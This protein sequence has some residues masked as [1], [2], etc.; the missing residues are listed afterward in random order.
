VPLLHLPANMS[1]S[2]ESSPQ[3]LCKGPCGR[4]HD[5]ADFYLRGT[6]RRGKLYRM[7]VCRTCH[8][9][10]QRNRK[11]RRKAHGPPPQ[12]CMNCGNAAPLAC[13]HDHQTGEFRGWLC[14]NCN[15]GLGLL[16]DDAAGLRRMLAYLTR[17][18][19]S[20]SGLDSEERARSRSPSRHGDF[21]GAAAS[22]TS[23]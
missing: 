2:S 21:G 12:H 6:S 5:I 7:T 17:S 11:R 10:E 14:K 18:T 1:D 13:D 22:P 3:R 4:E 16:G 15:T 20:S 23:L 8:V 19:A 9:L